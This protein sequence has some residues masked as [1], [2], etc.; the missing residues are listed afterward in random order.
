[1]EYRALG[2]TGL[3]VSV[4]AFGAGPVA[5]IMIEGDPGWQRACVERA[6]A[7][8]I[9]WFDTA[10][11]YGTGASE[12]NLGRCLRELGA[13]GR[14]HVATKV[15]LYP[16]DLSDPYAAARSSL[17]SS[18]ERLGLRRVALLQLHNAVA[19]TRSVAPDALAFEDVLGPKGVLHALIRLRTE[20]LADHLGITATGSP[21][22][23]EALLATREFAAAQVPYHV[24][25]P[26][27]GRPM[28]PGWA[29]Q[30]H[31]CLIDACLHHGVGVLAI[32]VF[33]GGAL[34][35]KPASAHTRRT[36]YFPLDLYERDLE[37]A[38]A[39][40][41]RLPPGNS[42]AELALRFVVGDCRVCAAIV[43]FT[44]PQEIDDAV[45]AAALGP[46]S[47]QQI[48]QVT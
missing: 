46:P 6:L 21:A 33:A 40:A 35:G 45:R 25:N 24:L 9:N 27:A 37:R 16:S 29:E 31:G 12:R 34:A 5:Q 11:G 14:V 43:G 19:E 7:A 18:L 1:M 41:A 28:P 48:A 8:G 32:R 42:L 36:R 44:S 4:L 3:A 20:G 2:N 30:D 13:A 17:E 26:S 23:T 47:A 15:R 22:A 39:I 38:A 10:P